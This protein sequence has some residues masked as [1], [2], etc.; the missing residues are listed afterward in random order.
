LALIP[1]LPLLPPV[2]K[3]SPGFPDCLGTNAVYSCHPAIAFCQVIDRP[4]LGQISPPGNRGKSKANDLTGGNRANRGRQ[5]HGAE[6]LRY[7]C[8]LML[9]RFSSV[10]PWCS[11]ACMVT[12]IDSCRER[13]IA[14]P[15]PR[16]PAAS[17]RPRRRE[18]F[19][20]KSKNSAAAHQSQ[21]KG[22]DLTG[23]NRDNRGRQ[24]HGAEFLRYLCCLL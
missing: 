19:T 23:G 5:K 17:T 6:F 16:L 8:W 15:F 18:D 20:T 9:E 7:L 2:G 24:K 3:F 14:R 10:F 4:P 1:P 12:L 22:N 11:D 13:S 21:T